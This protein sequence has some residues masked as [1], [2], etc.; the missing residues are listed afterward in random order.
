[1]NEASEEIC[2]LCKSEIQSNRLDEK[3]VKVTRGLDAIIAASQTRGDN[4]WLAIKDLEQVYVHAACRNA[5]TKRPKPP[6]SLQQ[7][8]ADS[9]PLAK[10]FVLIQIKTSVFYKILL[11]Y[12]IEETQLQSRVFINLHFLR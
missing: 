1:M 6:T 4:L 2:V 11:I 12:K 8:L 7:D 9:E 3:L 10:V 5:Y